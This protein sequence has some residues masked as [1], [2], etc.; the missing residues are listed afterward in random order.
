MLASCS[1][2][3]PNAGQLPR[4]IRQ[5][6]AC[7]CREKKRFT[8]IQELG[9]MDSTALRGT[10]MDLLLDVQWTRRSLLVPRTRL[11]V[12]VRERLLLSPGNLPD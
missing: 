3:P 4:P 10:P 6:N 5:S 8:V 9:G 2:I 1:A 12:T 11:T 7:R